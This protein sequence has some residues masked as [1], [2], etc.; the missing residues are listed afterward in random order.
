MVCR[1]VERIETVVFILHLGTICH[2]ESDFAEA[3]DNVLRYLS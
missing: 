2:G 3:A 1:R